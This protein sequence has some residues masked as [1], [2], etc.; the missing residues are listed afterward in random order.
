MKTTSISQL[1]ATGTKLDLLIAEIQGEVKVTRLAPKKARKAD[2]RADRVGG[3]GT[4]WAPAARA[5]RDG[6]SRIKAGAA[7]VR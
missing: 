6:G 7:K 1:A 4:R 2:L 3:G 5:P